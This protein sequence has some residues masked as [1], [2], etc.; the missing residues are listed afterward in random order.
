MP[1]GMGSGMNANDMLRTLAGATGLT[2]RQADDLLVTGLTVLS[3]V[4]SA[5]ETRDL[6]AQ[7]P[8]SFRERIPVSTTTVSMRPIEFVA[9]VQELT[10]AAG[11]DPERMVRAVFDVL[12]QAVNAGEMNDIA[13]QL[14]DD[15]ATLLG[16]EERVRREHAQAAAAEP[17]L[18]PSVIGTAVSAG[19]ALVSA[20][21]RP[22]DAGLRLGGLRH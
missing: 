11:D 10:A 20:V 17:G 4:V 18:V 14:G 12:T 2:R 15:Y 3:E 19:R 16:R 5:E 1:A 6:L 22:V 21:W 7:L 13:A 8:K 9:R